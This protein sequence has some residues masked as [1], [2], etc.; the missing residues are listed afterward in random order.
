[1]ENN[2]LVTLDTKTFKF[3]YKGVKSKMRILL[4]NY[5]TV[6]DK[7]K[8]LTHRELTAPFMNWSLK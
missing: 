7:T 6:Y 4:I 5:F 1:M 3:Y 8:E 2:E